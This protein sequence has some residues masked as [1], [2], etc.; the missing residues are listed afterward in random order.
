M[1]IV[2]SRLLI[3]RISVAVEEAVT[4]AVEEEEE[5]VEEEEEEGKFNLHRFIALH[6]Q[7]SIIIA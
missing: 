5:T 4:V 6:W 2:F 1:H 3:N 7:D